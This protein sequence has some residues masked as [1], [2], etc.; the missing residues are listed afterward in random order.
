MSERRYTVY[1]KDPERLDFENFYK[2]LNKKEK[3]DENNYYETYEETY[4][5]GRKKKEF[6][7]GVRKKFE[8]AIENEGFWSDNYF[9]NRAFTRSLVEYIDRLGILIKITSIS[10]WDPQLIILSKNNTRG[11]KYLKNPE[12]DTEERFS[13]LD[14]WAREM[15]LDYYSKEKAKRRKNEL[16]KRNN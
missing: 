11:K 16:K 7:K 2:F 3:D 14:Y 5:C 9:H 1:I 12:A 6:K 13:H 4:L 8:N 10:G 15:G